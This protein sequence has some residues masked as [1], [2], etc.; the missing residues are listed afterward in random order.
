MKL[1]QRVGTEIRKWE[2]EIWRLYKSGVE[3]REAVRRAYKKHPVFDYVREN[4]KAELPT[5][6]RKGYGEGDMPEDVAE[7]LADIPWSKDGLNLS[8]RTT[9]GSRRVVEAVGDSLVESIREGKSTREAAIALF[10]GYAE[11]GIIPEQDIPKYMEKLL[12]L[13]PAREYGGTEYKAALRSAERHLGKLSTR[14]MKA[15]YNQILEAIDEGNEEKVQKAVYVATQEKT[16]YFAERI[17]RTEMARAYFDGFLAKNMDDPDVVAFRL[18]LS[19]RHPEPDICD[20]YAKSDMFGMGKGIYPKDRLPDYPFHPHCMCVWEPVIAGSRKLKSETPKPQIDEGVEVYLNKLSNG[21]R[22]HILGVHGAET[23]AKTGEWR[24][25][26]LSWREP[27]LQKSRLAGEGLIPRFEALEYDDVV[28][29][30]TIDEIQKTADNLDKVIQK[31]F[32]GKSEWS[33]KVVLAEEG[34]LP[35]KLWNCDVRMTSK[36]SE[37]ILIHE[38][39]HARSVSLTDFDTYKKYN[40][41]EE[42]TVELLNREIC[43]AESIPYVR[44]DYAELIKALE[45]ISDSCGYK[46][47]LT[48]AKEALSVNL[49]DRYNWLEEKYLDKIRRLGTGEMEKYRKMRE[50]LDLLWK[51]S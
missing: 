30:M 5:A 14:S 45:E 50:A 18:R 3:P 49:N 37:S 27:K 8:Q 6:A 31:H 29:E 23:Y 39:I 21:S 33:G 32:N 51:D 47:Y 2:L 12:K 43:R 42:G 22:Q 11:G 10:N 16:R 25:N 28:K 7:R 24:D 34:E 40:L 26:L 38:L 4:I 19:T 1:S 15:A 35:G 20:L 41:V 9:R 13:A 48:F 44:S 36:T 17:A 46:D